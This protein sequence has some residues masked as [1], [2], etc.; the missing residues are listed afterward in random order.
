M[1]QSFAKG[2][3]AI[4]K[5]VWSIKTDLM[6]VGMQI[7]KSIREGLIDALPDIVAALLNCLK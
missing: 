6:Q 5:T 2:F 4:L 1:T 7:F 3:M